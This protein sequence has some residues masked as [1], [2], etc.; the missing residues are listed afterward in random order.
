MIPTI[1]QICKDLFAARIT[2][3]Q[4][5]A[6]L[7]QH[8]DGTASELRDAFAA[9]ALTGFLSNSFSDGVN[10]PLSHATALEMAELSYR[11]ADEMLKRRGPQHGPLE[12]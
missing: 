5:I 1:E 11:Q 12:K 6:W 2:V 3:D 7:H 4:A 9:A 8:A 10:K